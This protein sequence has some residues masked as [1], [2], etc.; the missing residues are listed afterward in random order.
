M[1]LKNIED[2]KKLRKKLGITQKEL[3]KISGVSQSLIA[4][5]ESGVVEPSYSKAIKLIDALENYS[6]NDKK[7]CD[8]MT[9]KIIFCKPN[10]RVSDAVKT[11]QK[12]KI[13]QMPV[14]ENDKCVGLIS[15]SSILKAKLRGNVS[16]VKDCLEPCPP[17]INDKSDLRMISS[18]L[19]FSPIVLVVKSGR[20][21][22]VI[23]K[24]DVIN[25]LN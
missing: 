11:M 15:E 20:F 1:I 22:G 7:A 17:M 3:S 19:E 24:S 4:K 9:K 25:G 10:D 12:Y 13:S 2:I 14:L 5:I 16:C 21:I 6:S 23:T 18:L 8:I